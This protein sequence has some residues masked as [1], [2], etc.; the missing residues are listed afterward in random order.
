M[1]ILKYI[2]T[3]LILSQSMAAFACGPYFPPE[4]AS[5]AFDSSNIVVVA[6][7]TGVTLSHFEESNKNYFEK[8]DFV[9]SDGSYVIAIPDSRKHRFLLVQSIKGNAE[10]IFEPE[11]QPCGASVKLG[12]M[13]ILFLSK[14][15]NEYFLND[16]VPESYPEYKKYLEYLRKQIN[17]NKAQKKGAESNSAS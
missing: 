8:K 3:F 2:L 14:E 17:D 12:E 1:N 10:Q 4:K 11:S 5:D 16:V 13:N 9:N 6:L 15:N 7:S